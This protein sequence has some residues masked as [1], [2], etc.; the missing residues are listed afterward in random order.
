MSGANE[1]AR[2]DAR[3]LLD[4]MRP[5]A[6]GVVVVLVLVAIQQGAWLLEPAVFG[7]LIDAVDVEARTWRDLVGAMPLWTV[8]FAVNT[9][10][11]GLRRVASERVYGTMYA[12]LAEGLAGRA[13]QQKLDAAHTASLSELARDFVGFFEDR[14]PDA[15]MGAVSLVGALGALFTYDL[16]IGAACLVVLGPL[17]VVGRVYDRR[18]SKLTEELH[19]LREQ[20]VDVFSN[21]TPE[22][23]GKHFR[24]VADLKRRIGTWSATNFG[25]LRASLF[26]V[27]VVVLYVAID[28]DDMTVGAI[29]SI[30]TY[31][32]TY[33]TAIEDLPELLENLTAVRD[34][35]KRLQGRGNG[36]VVPPPP[37][38]E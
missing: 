15:I 37:A 25:V 7:Q 34:L 36:P 1:A 8:V 6:R 23:I 26:A 12:R 13:R 29:Y 10:A 27:F 9:I 2:K 11:G 28:V 31:L 30:V 14:L 21:Q 19:E 20:N 33:V 3:S 4:D 24:R 5:S 17:F 16:R 18:V 32:W 35:T 38:E 22:D